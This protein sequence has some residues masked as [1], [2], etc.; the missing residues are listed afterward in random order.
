MF[1]STLVILFLVVVILACGIP[2]PD[3]E[4]LS[5]SGNV[6]TREEAITGFDKLDVSQGFQVDV[7]QGDTF[8][9]VIRVDDNL[10][11][12][13]RVAK[14]GNTLKI[15]L[16][17]GRSFSLHN[18]TLEADVTMPELTGLDLE[19]GSHATINGLRSTKALDAKLSSGSH[20]QGDVDVGDAEFDISGGSHVTLSGSAGDL[21]IDASGGSHG[22]LADLAVGDANVK[23]NG[24]SHVTVNPS[25]SLNAVAKGGSHVRYVGSP[26]LG[27]I[28]ADV[29]SSFKQE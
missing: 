25:G 28:N 13:V 16:E 24:G 9:V 4:S 20:L 10:I 14:E 23:A 26:T 1:K 5:G 21:V 3:F 17:P 12:R 8:S 18:A 2:I 15:G 11:E 6:V 19:S 29:S 22:K 27:T 7:R